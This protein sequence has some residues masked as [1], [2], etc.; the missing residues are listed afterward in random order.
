MSSIP[1]K[2]FL[3][4]DVMT[5]RGIDQIMPNRCDPGLHEH[6]ARSALDYVALAQQKSGA[7][8]QSADFGYVWGDA[9]AELERAMPDV[10][11]INL[12]TALTCSDD[13][14]RG[15]SIHYRMHPK[16]VPFFKIAGIDCCVL[17]NNHVIDWGQCGLA[18]TIE[19][20]ALAG[21]ETTGAGRDLKAAR[22]PATIEVAGKGRVLVFGIGDESSG[23]AR[24]WAAA[25]D[26]P[27]V[28]LVE[29]LSKTTWRGI[30]DQVRAIKGPG[31]LAVISVHWGGNWGYDLSDEHIQF[32]RA[33]VDECGV[34]IVHGHSSHHA[35]AIEVYHGKLVL[36]GCGDLINDYEGIS[37]YENFRGDLGL[38]YFVTV[39]IASGSLLRLEMTA[40]TLRRF[41]AN[42]AENAD[43]QW[44]AEMLTREGAR[45]G[46]RAVP[47]GDDRLELYWR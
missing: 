36:Y 43:A 39:D 32:A 37:G 18:E 5:G 31:D 11:I 30:G 22:T 10:R 2:L 16:N 25:A 45:F 13:Y 4:G 12:E 29:N 6:Y 34:D 14:W 40:T 42:R 28:N 15:K 23:I 35:K 9:L 24:A 1:L 38:M 47:T 20:L 21:I 8:T 41:R 26:R 46:T 19:T 7:F 33:L 17:A 44:I 3:C 27:G